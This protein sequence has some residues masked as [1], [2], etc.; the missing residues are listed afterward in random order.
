MNIKQQIAQ[1]FHQAERPILICHFSPDG[2]ALGSI[3]GLALALQKINKAPDPVCQDPVP[4]TFSYLC[5]A[6]QVRTQP[7]GEYDLIVS[8]DCSDV[9]RMGTPYQTLALQSK[10]I[11]IINIDHHV[12]NINFGELNWVDPT[13]VSSSEMV[14]EL[15]ETMGIPLDPNIATCL[16][17]GIVSDTRS[18]RTSNISP[19]VMAAATRLME[20]GASL[21]EITSQVFG[22]RPM[23]AVRLWAQALPETHL[24]DRILWSVVTQ[25]MREQSSY[26]SNGDAGLASFLGDVKEADM[27]AVFTERENGEIDV[28]MR[29]NP[30]W[31]VSQ[32]ALSLGGGG[33]PQ[34]AGCT[35]KTT[36]QAAID[37]VLPAIR[38]AWQEQAGQ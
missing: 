29:A 2:D 8:L 27:T 37:T 3:L 21:A 19:K 38:T 12:T 26:D 31:D 6:D 13:A 25:E 34:A 15:L 18:F 1:R 5:G 10:H 9:R 4:P 22:H 36:L 24:D 20:A 17:T 16:L 33:H 7:S 23:A 32:V 30:G 28:S 11:P 35:L 14:L